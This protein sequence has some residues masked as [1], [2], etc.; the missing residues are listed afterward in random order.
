MTSAA[1]FFSSGCSSTGIPRPSSITVT[2]SS[3]WIDMVTL[4][5]W[6]ANASSIELSTAS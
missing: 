4:V 3:S 1:D 2:E 5:Q 6:P